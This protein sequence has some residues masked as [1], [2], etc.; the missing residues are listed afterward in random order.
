[1][2]SKTYRLVALLLVLCMF[3]LACYNKYTISTEQL[4]QLESGNIAEY[5]TLQAEGRD[6]V[7]SA[8]TPVQVRTM[9]GTRYNVSP[10]NFALGDNQLV[11][12]DYDLLLPRDE[13]DGARVTQ[14]AKG[15]T[16]A[17]IVGS[18]VLAGGAFALMSILAP[19]DEGLSQ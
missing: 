13:I 19:E 14:F 6:V 7:V 5:V 15:R 11:A 2:L 1:M 16:I 4:E 8:T 12:P 3:Q 17:L 9:S 18:V 10:F